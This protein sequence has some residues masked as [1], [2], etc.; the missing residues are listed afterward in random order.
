MDFCRDEQM[1]NKQLFV[2]TIVTIG[3]LSASVAKRATAACGLSTSIGALPV[4]AH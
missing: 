1:L 2:V 4:K 3:E